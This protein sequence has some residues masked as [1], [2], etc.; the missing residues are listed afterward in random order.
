[1]MLLVGTVLGWLGIGSL[2][3]VAFL[4]NYL[5]VGT[6]FPEKVDWQ[7]IAAIAIAWPWPLWVWYSS[8]NTPIPALIR[9]GIM[10]IVFIGSLGLGWVV[11]LNLYD[12]IYPKELELADKV[13]IGALIEKIIDPKWIGDSIAKVER[14][15]ERRLEFD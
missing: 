12:T 5:R 13:A 8:P 2:V 3:G 15:E 10:T 1:M 4:K 6:R 9:I 11:G 7:L 14:L